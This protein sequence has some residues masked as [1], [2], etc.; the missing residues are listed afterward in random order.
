MNGKDRRGEKIGWLGGWAGAFCCV[1]ILGI[2]FLAQG[3]AAAGIGGI[4]LAA[5]GMAL[6]FVARPWRHPRTSYWKLMLAPFACYAAAI[7]WVF[8]CFGIERLREEG[9]N[10]W[11]LLPMASIFA[12]PF[13]VMGRRRWS[14]E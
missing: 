13:F 2:V 9:F 10:W 1:P 5:L 7:A 12:V 8:L 4:L 3:H 6:V 11:L 14:D